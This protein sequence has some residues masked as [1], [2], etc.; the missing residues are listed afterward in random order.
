MGWFAFV[1]RH[2]MLHALLHFAYLTALMQIAIITAWLSLTGQAERNSELLWTMMISLIII[3]PV[4]GFLPALSATVYY[5]VPGMAD[6]MPDLVA[7][8]SGH[9]AVLDLPRLQGLISFPS[10]HTTLGILFPY[11]LRR[12][13]LALLI[14][15]LLNAAMLAAVPTEGSH[16]L[17]DMIGGAAVAA[18][19]IM[20]AAGIAARLARRPL[21]AA[22]AADAD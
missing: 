21:P 12:H 10:F 16:Y 5:G 11:V 17:V 1:Q 6:H 22:L 9:L 2:P 15:V 4:S 20:A 14:G 13:R 3:V 8:R 7:L 18:I 19:A